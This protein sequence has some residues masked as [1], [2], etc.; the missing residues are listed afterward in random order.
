[1]APHNPLFSVIGVSLLWIGWFG[2]SA[3]SGPVGREGRG[4]SSCW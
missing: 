4:R 2:F 3:G 1:M